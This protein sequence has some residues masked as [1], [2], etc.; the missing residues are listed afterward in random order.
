MEPMLISNKDIVTIRKKREERC[1][2]N[3]VVL[4]RKKNKLILH[5]IIQVLPDNL[6]VIL[7]DNCSKKEYGISDED[8]LGIVIAFKHNGKH[9]EINDPDYQAYVKELRNIEDNRIKKKLLYDRIMW[10]IRFL[11]SNILLRIKPRLKKMIFVNNLDL[12]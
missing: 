8:I 11:P 2:E 7:G 1:K 5:R 3:D 6:Y 10:N 4:Y 9:Y 12:K